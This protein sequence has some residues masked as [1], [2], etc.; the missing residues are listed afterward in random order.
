MFKRVLIGSGFRYWVW[1]GCWV[2]GVVFLEE[3]RLRREVGG[4]GKEVF[5]IVF[6]IS[7]IYWW[8]VGF[9]GLECVGVV[10]EY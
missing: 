6:S 10:L 2:E 3:V 5:V 7:I 9:L 8:D 4:V 1:W